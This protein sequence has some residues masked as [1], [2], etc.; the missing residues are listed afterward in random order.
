MKTCIGWGMRWEEPVRRQSEH[1]SDYEQSLRRLM[2][3]KPV[4][5]AFMSRGEMR[6]HIVEQEAAGKSWP[7]D[8]DGV[9]LYPGLDKALSEKKR[10]ALI[11]EESRSPGG[12]T[13][14]LPSPGSAGRWHGQN[15]QPTI[16]PS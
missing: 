5:P 7:R 9:P 12:W 10:A 13:W 4:Y 11:D 14:R 2:D 1:F 16:P 15:F 3:E 8:P 6:A